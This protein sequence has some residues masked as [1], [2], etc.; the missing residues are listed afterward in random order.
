[1]ENTNDLLSRIQ[2]LTL[3]ILLYEYLHPEAHGWH[4]DLWGEYYALEDVVRELCDNAR[5]FVEESHLIN[6]ELFNRMTEYID[7]NRLGTVWLSLEYMG[8]VPFRLEKST[9][10]CPRCGKYFLYAFVNSHVIPEIGCNSDEPH[11]HFACACYKKS[12]SLRQL[13]YKDIPKVA[14]GFDYRTYINSLEWK[15]KAEEAKKR[16]GHRCQICNRSR[17]ETVLNAHHRTYERLG[18]ELPEDITVLCRGCHRL[19]EK[20]RKMISPVTTDGTDQLPPE[21]KISDDIAW[22]ELSPANYIATTVL[23]KK[24]GRKP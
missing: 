10:K 1:M 15:Q 11:L 2:Q 19:Y 13:I 7:T 21:T 5:Q 16:V 23:S 3:K 20:N 17:D 4:D 18:N 24:N 6:V 22:G 8:D 12:I 14:E 9:F